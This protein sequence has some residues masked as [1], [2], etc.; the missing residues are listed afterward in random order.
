MQNKSTGKTVLIVLLLLIT[1]ASLILATFAWARY[2]TVIAGSSSAQ[3]AQWDVEFENSSSKITKTYNHVVEDKL[4]PGTDGSITMAITS[5]NTETAYDF[6]ISIKNLQNKPTNL[7]FYSDSTFTKPIDIS[8][9]KAFS[10][11]VKLVN[12]KADITKP[13]CVELDIDSGTLS[14][15]SAVIYWKWEYQTKDTTI[16]SNLS[17]ITGTTETRVLN[18]LKIL[19][20][21]KAVTVDGTETISVL[22]K[23]MKDA[24]VAEADIATVINDA[25]DTVDGMAA[26]TMS[27]D[28][29]FEATQTQ[30]TSAS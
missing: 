30:P 15:G 12:N 21:E 19:A 13:E 28:V 16:L 7:K 23:K 17:S 18:D 4:A 10:G 22:V 29:E 20:T 5:A 3:V 14:A 27:F 6:A 26:E 9:G 1:I 24:S 11:H 25:I 8:T 2:T